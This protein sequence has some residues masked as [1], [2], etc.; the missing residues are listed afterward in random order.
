MKSVGNPPGSPSSSATFVIKDSVL[1]G[2]FTAL[3]YD[4]DLLSKYR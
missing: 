1:N 3:N 4:K 2:V